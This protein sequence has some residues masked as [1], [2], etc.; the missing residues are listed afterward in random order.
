MLSLKLLALLSL[1]ILSCAKIKTIY[2]KKGTKFAFH[3]SHCSSCKAS[4]ESI[5]TKEGVRQCYTYYADV[6][7]SE[8]GNFC[9]N[10]YEVLPLPKSQKENDQLTSLARTMASNSL[11][12]GFMALDLKPSSNKNY[13]DSNG[14]VPLY[15]NWASAVFAEYSPNKS[16]VLM[17][18]QNDGFWFNSEQTRKVAL[19]CKQVCKGKLPYSS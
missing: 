5:I 14:N 1:S 3:E 13:V 17:F 8:A 19:I 4:Y 15:T 7:L 6:E 9:K 18:T 12:N 11:S 2:P 16:P 10:A